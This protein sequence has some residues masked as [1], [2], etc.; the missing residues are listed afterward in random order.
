MR[1]LLLSVILFIATCGLKAQDLRTC[2]DKEFEDV[3]R[4]YVS[5]GN[6]Q[7]DRSYRFGIKLYADSL[8]YALRLRSESGRFKS[9]KAAED[10]LVYTAHLL[11]LRADWH[12]ENGNY[13]SKSYTE[14]EK[15]FRQALAVYE[16]HSGL[17]GSL[18]RL[19]IIQREM[20]QLMYK[21]ERYDE[22][23]DY[24]NKAYC[25]Y[26]SAYENGGFDETDKLYVTLLD[27]KS[28]K[29]IC[30]ARTGRAEDGLVLMDELL[31]V[32]PKS[33]EGFYEV[34]R[35]KGKILMLSQKPGCDKDALKLYKQYLTWRK[36]DALNTLG[37]M[38]SAEREDYWMRIRPFVADCY[39]LESADPGF[40]Y[41]VTLFSKG[42]LLQL[43]RMS[44]HGVASEKALAS[45]RHT[46]QQVQAKL[47]K[48]AC[49]IE[50]VQYEKF[51]KPLMGAIVLGKTGTPKWV[52]MMSPEEFMQY[53][54]GAW[55]NKERLYTTDGKRKNSMYNDSTLCGTIWNSELRH[56]IGS[57]RNVYFAPDGY[58]HQLAIEYM[59]PVA[60]GDKDMYRLTSTRKILEDAKIRTEA[61]LVV[62][63]VRYDACVI[64]SHVGNDS[65]AYS[66]MQHAR[67]SFYYLPGSLNEGSTIYAL[68]SCRGD[69]L[70]I[71]KEATEL[72]FR[73]L[74]NQYP[75]INISTHGYFGSAKVPQSTD[76]KT[77]M[78]DETLSQC[79]IAMAGTN[80]NILATDY[81]A[82]MMDGL[83][84][85]R[86]ISDTD[87]SEVDLAI[88]SA[89][90]TGLGYVTADGV[91]GIQRGL[92]NAGVKSLIVSLWNVDDKATCLLMTYFHKNLQD[93]MTVH[94]AFMEARN[95]LAEKSEQ[96]KAT[97][98]FSPSTLAGQ[99][100]Q[101][102][103][104]YD[105]PQ[106]RNAFILI[107]AI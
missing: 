90:Q 38:T 75:I 11:K 77:C 28:Q 54:I 73:T 23:L 18:T 92:K 47:R 69:S 41:D 14:A 97:K 83:L 17:V 86:E 7:Y 59:V 60:I 46:W 96:S 42:L 26:D 33:S 85:A 5:K 53:E 62:G 80:T 70:L 63:G 81:D 64:D 22:A 1:L 94:K 3:V 91:F 79:V 50:F 16:N 57:A 104:R 65:M 107:D 76:V 13:D 71:G 25:A 10:S 27:L 68:R 48:D 87:M 43:N 15:L 30:L 103:I 2:S 67:A 49:A 45:L 88:I 72:A 36:A 105:K 35:K 61:A 4:S 101:N 34:L 66:Y 82:Q 100:S 39:Q 89:C 102:D 52:K 20:A 55:T 95:S 21:L 9:R 8:E 84:S 106:Y 37:T 29:A 78:S 19:P 74:C 56:A 32:Y 6:Y 12:Y 24:T 99:V 58:L 31:K 93:G 40:L 98:I 44:G 51:G